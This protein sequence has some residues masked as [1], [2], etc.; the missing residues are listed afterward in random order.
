VK[1]IDTLSN[2][3]LEIYHPKTY[4]SPGIAM[5]KILQSALLL[6]PLFFFSAAN[7]TTFTFSYYYNGINTPKVTGAISGTQVGNLIT[8]LSDVKLWVNGVQYTDNLFIDSYWLPGRDAVMST[9]IS[10]NN[11][12]FTGNQ[13][14]F[15]I[16]TGT[17]KYV[18]TAL[19]SA[20]GSDSDEA[21]RWPLS[22]LQSRWHIE[23][24]P[25]PVPEPETYALFLIGI[26]A[27]GVIKRRRHAIVA[28]LT[29]SPSL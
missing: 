23:A 21:H 1:V 6:L 13:F 28:N 5:K 29:S 4:S 16:G 26:G 3:Y 7:A 11:F 8:D 20:L 10:L 18:E 12:S 27:I 2:F 19:S 14:S 9:D 24:V 15:H 17:A 22:D 25:E